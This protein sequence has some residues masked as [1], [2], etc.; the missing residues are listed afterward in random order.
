MP[1]K[2]PSLCFFDSYPLKGGKCFSQL[3]SK[4]KKILWRTQ[5]ENIVFA[6]GFEDY[7]EGLKACSPKE[8][9]LG[10]I[11]LEFI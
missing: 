8:T 4:A 11:N 5:M 6:N 9:N 1:H 2:G 3:P 10:T 7:I